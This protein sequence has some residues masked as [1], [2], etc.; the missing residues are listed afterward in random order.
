MTS[1][2]LTSQEI[3][4]FKDTGVLG[5]FDLLS[6]S[7]AETTLRALRFEKARLF[8]WHRLL[9]RSGA[10]DHFL[11]KKRWGKAEWGK[12]L[13]LVSQRTRSFS[14]HPMI[15]DK[16]ESLM[17]TDLVQW[18][19]SLITQVPNTIHPWHVDSE[20]WESEGVTAWI[21]LK[22]VSSQATVKVITRSHLLHQ[23]PKSLQ[24]E[25]D[26]RNVSDERM[27]EIVR[28]FDSDAELIRLDAKP[29]QFYIFSCKVW[30]KAANIS[31]LHR[32][33][34][35]FQYSPAQATL[36]MPNK[37]YSLPILEGT[38]PIPCCLVRGY[39]SQSSNRIV[40]N[41]CC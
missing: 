36:K 16:I 11:P 3:K 2:Y 41:S 20:C 25:G 31:P 8:L 12:G 37:D 7:E 27:L 30:H 35:T 19:T 15:L 13:H 39:A 38:G 6:E 33:I 22:N 9:S 10:L 21:A 14:T 32:S 18:G 24:I 1:H 5:P 17:G 26:L 34:A 40:L 23:H 4:T 28:S 29:G